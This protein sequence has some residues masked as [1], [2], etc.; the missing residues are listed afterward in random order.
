MGMAQFRGDKCRIA[1]AIIIDEF[2]ELPPRLR[3]RRRPKG[4]R[5]IPPWNVLA[6]RRPPEKR[7]LSVRRF[8]Q[9]RQKWSTEPI[10]NRKH[11]GSRRR[12]RAR[13]ER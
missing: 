10:R 11:A 13:R 9:S 5:E 2:I 3:G 8:Q 4:R 7:P 12:Q 1:L 6:F